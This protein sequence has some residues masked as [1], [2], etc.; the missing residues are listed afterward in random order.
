MSP[1]VKSCKPQIKLMFS[2]LPPIADIGRHRRYPQGVAGRGWEY[3]DR[4]AARLW[5]AA[6]GAR[7]RTKDPHLSILH[8]DLP[9]FREWGERYCSWPAT[10]VGESAT[11]SRIESLFL[12]QRKSAPARRRQAAA[13]HRRARKNPTSASQMDRRG[14]AQNHARRFHKATCRRCRT[15][16]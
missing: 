1:L 3:A 11:K 5:C 14:R 2:T 12:S 10:T 16:R 7:A 6:G 4:E 8:D 15:A 13:P 9:P